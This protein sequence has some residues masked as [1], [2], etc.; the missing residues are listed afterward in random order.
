MMREDAAQVIA[1][2]AQRYPTAELVFHEQCFVEDGHFAGDDAVRLSAFVSL[3]NDTAIDA[4]W[5]GRGGYGACRIAEDAVKLLKAPAN[6]K[7]YLGYSDA[8]N[9]LGALYKAGI[10]WPV[11]GPMVNDI[12]REGGEA[13]VIRALDWLVDR[14]AE[15]FEQH[16]E[17][18]Q[19]YAAFN[20]MTL[21]MMIGT[22]LMPDLSGHVLLVEEVSEY[23]YAFDRAMFNLT[24]H[25]K[26]MGLAGLRLGR[27]SDITS[28]DR[29]FGMD[30][31]AIAQHWCAKNRIAYLGRADIGHD[32][33][34]Q[35]VPFGAF[36]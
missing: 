26:S 8:G 6:A 34:N 21:T 13:A 32:V 7:S 36:S 24:T 22:P 20:L 29:P 18:G 17:R 14:R 10:G 30:A 5:F 28:N 11:H 4:I 9:L 25:L 16:L 27:V 19:K 33:D 23:L 35:I 2:A 1:L 31:E 12:K 15:T 3:A